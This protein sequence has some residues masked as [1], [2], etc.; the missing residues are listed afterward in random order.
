MAKSQNPG[1]ESAQIFANFLSEM[2]ALESIEDWVSSL[3][4]G[5]WK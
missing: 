1:R 5:L 2:V 4:S 3:C